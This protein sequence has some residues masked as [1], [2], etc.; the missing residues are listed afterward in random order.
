MRKQVSAV[1]RVAQRHRAKNAKLPRR[2]LPAAKSAPLDSSASK[3][4][5][6]RRGPP[7]ALDLRA[8]PSR[9]TGLKL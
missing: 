7:R 2:L 3:G 4:C 8:S 5:V 9:V 6:S 1:K